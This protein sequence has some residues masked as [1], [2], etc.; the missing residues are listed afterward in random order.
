MFSLKEWTLCK[1][2]AVILCLILA[3]ETH[4]LYSR[5]ESPE[6]KF[7]AAKQDYLHGDYKNAKATLEGILESVDADKP[8][9]RVFLGYV[10]LLLG[11]CQE[12]LGEN[13]AAR[14][15]YLKAKELLEEKEA[16]IEGISFAGLLIYEEIFGSKK[17]QEEDVLVV[18]F[19][20]GR[21]AYFAGDYEAAKFVLETLVT[22]LGSVEGRD[23]F[24][25]ETYLLMGAT[26]EKLKYKELAIKYYCKA[27]QILGEGKTIE[28]LELKK[29]K[30]YRENCAQALMAV[31]GAKKGSFF[32]KFLG[33]LL[34]LAVVGGLIWYLFFSKNAPFKKKVEEYV[35]SSACFTSSWHF[36][37]YSEWL[38]TAGTTSLTPQTPPNPNENNN[39]DDS[40][41]Y[42]LSASGGTLIK[43]ELK[44]SL[45]I[46]GGDGVTRTDTVYIDGGKI[47][48]D[49]NTFSQSC[50]NRTYEKDFGVIYS[51]NSV[52]TFTVRHQVNLK[53]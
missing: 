33:T 5:Q 8:E 9:N 51:R 42:T 11:G 32:G 19:N 53:K 37:V 1:T 10:F 50:S 14:K 18:E 21:D 34:G 13:E 12:K 7:E 47:L 23:T 46:S 40:V 41:T 25:G 15:S 31:A 3:F 44:L 24:K 35:Y 30:Y 26:Y 48:E 27:K 52:G 43:I 16:T 4:Y 29:L 28:G 20:K 49:T 39:W 22:T 38:G 6:V 17:E 45:K 2:L 36:E